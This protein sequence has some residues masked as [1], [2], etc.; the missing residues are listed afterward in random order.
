[1][2]DDEKRRGARRRRAV[3][4]AV[5][6]LGV[7]VAVA[8]GLPQA[9]WAQSRT[10]GADRSADRFAA[11]ADCPPTSEICLENSLPGN[12]Y[13]EWNVPGAGSS[14][15]QGY[16]VQMSVNKGETA[17]F[18][19][20]TPATA[21]RMDIY[22]VGYYGGMGA[23]KITTIRPS[24]PLPQTQPACLND[25]AT[26]LIDC[27]NWSVSA[28]WAVP[29]DAVSGVYLANMVR[30]DGVSGVSQLIFVVRDDSGGSDLLV[31]TADATWQAYNTYGGNSLY[32]GSPAGRAFKVS[33]NRPVITRAKWPETYFFDSEYPMVRWLEANGY[34]VSYTS[35][36]D[37]ASR[38][39]EL[40]EHK[41]FFAMGHAEYWSNEMRDNVQNA[42][43]AGINLA[44]F[45]GNDVFWKT[46]WENGIDSSGAPFRTLVCYK[47]TLAN[48]KI[49]PSPQWTGTWRDPRFSPPSNGGRPE[50]AVTG[51]LYRVNG[52]VSDSIVVPA[53]YGPMRLWRNTSIA[54]L[55]P[56]EQA[57]FPAGTL[58]Y[59]W[60]E[61]PEDAF[62]PQGPVKLSETTLANPTKILLDFGGTYGP[63]VATHHLTLYK[64]TSGA[65]VFG[66]GTIQWSWGLDAN[67]DRGAGTPTDI[68]MQQATVNLLADMRVQ[69]ASLQAGLVPATPS[70]D[71]TPPTSAITSPSSGASVAGQTPVSIQGTAV[72]AGGGVVAGVE[73]SVD[74]GG[75]WQQATGRAN[76]R[77]DWTTGAP[78]PVTILSRAVDDIG[79]VQKTPTVLNVTVN[80]GCPCT[81][82]PPDA[83]PAEASKNDPV[84]IEV[85]VRFRS[86]SE[87]FITGIRFYKGPTNTGTHIGNLWTNTG[88]LLATATFTNETAGGWQQV[89]F[90]TPVPVRAGTTYVASYFAPVGNY[91]VTRDYFNKAYSNGLLTAL[92]N[93]TDGGNGL[94]TYSK[95]STFPTSTYR[96]TN[97]WVDVVFT[98]SSSL[99]DDTAVPAVPTQPDSK[100]VALGLKFQA[101]VPGFI[102]G[103]RFYKGPQNTGAHTGSLW[104]LDGQLLG[105]VTFTGETASGWQQAIFPTPIP[106]DA[107]TTYVISY[108]TT[109]GYY[110]VTRP[111]FTT[112]YSRGRLTALADGAAGGNGVYTYSGTN[113][114]P[115]S[116][117][118]AANYWVDVLFDGTQT[119][120]AAAAAAAA[121]RRGSA[122]D[123]AGRS[124]PD[125]A[126]PPVAGTGDS[127]DAAGPSAA[128][129]GGSRDA[130]P[131]RSRPSPRGAGGPATRLA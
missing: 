116:T 58:G 56:G 129:A 81:I 69:P 110:S 40:L 100:A 84:G 17:Q 9:V 26:G 83:T 46:R 85:G 13:S 15:I 109:S 38:G 106:I 12:P 52:N 44:F 51:T 19:V 71:V 79:N 93:G 63:G 61:T 10:P 29:G 101:S 18:K 7:C 66:A 97:A 82:W 55:Q 127:R 54:T 99:W 39:A 125:A 59:E 62:T 24:V 114:F 53:E 74:G 115:T 88:T 73:V 8:I 25:A 34:D 67:H 92:A 57:V 32:V 11:Q 119:P 75:T 2:R 21:Y 3:P 90:S 113:V 89:S 103:I 48:A 76:W 50:N 102:R 118:K 27:G 128:G 86:A 36:I 105:S 124:A 28:S 37:T 4:I 22:R 43:D 98:A 112:Q 23:R 47:E 45:T 78:G 42:R 123:P 108:H 1:M 31:Q 80:A 95:V 117:Y 68:R 94:Y 91:A 120:A 96:A 33:Y 131:E 60:N 16:P 20:A 30:E 72:D 104:T 126:E 49:D 35:S 5:L 107:S 64:V 121:P 65:L 14:N 122:P 111:Y 6:V 87:G 77:F 130:A 70:T 41:V